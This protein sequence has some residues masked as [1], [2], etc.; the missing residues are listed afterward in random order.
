[1]SPRS[2]AKILRAKI[3]ARFSGAGGADRVA[4]VV[5]RE[6]LEIDPQLLLEA[7]AELFANA[8]CN[9][10]GEGAAR[11]RRT[12]GRR[13]NCVFTLREP[14]AAAIA[15]T[16]NWGESPLAQLRHGHYALGLFRARSIFE[17]HHGTFQAQFDS[18]ASVLVTTVTL[19][20][21]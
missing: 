6:T 11:L 20:L 14:K 10:R 18:A 21:G 17:A 8:F 13:P 1:M 5:R 3:K 2:W 16:E 19:P 15:S 7:F 9:E 12:R 4:A